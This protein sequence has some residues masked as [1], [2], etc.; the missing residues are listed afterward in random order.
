MESAE[1]APVEPESR[2]ALWLGRL[3]RVALVL[4]GAP[5]ILSLAY[6]ILPPPVTGL[7][8]WKAA[9]G[10]GIDYRWVPLSQISP[11]LPI[12]VLAAEDTRFCQH[13]A[14]DWDSMSDVVENVMDDGPH[15]R[16]KL[17][18]ASTITMQTAKNLF[19][20]PGRSFLRKLLEAPLAVWIDFTWSKRRVLEVYLNVVEWGPGIYGAEAA[21]RAHFKKSASQ[22]TAREAA[23]LAAVLPNPIK[24][25]AGK[26][27]GYVRVYAA[28]INAR[29][30]GTVPFL[31]CLALKGP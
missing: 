22:L 12:A 2:R 10:Y 25:I 27:S 29:V 30:P 24:R 1:T 23:L 31:D 11:K 4:V 18:G 21:A 17:R 3:R 9:H 6:T 5:L 26:P 8:L 13:G 7:M 19:L 28:R 16:R 20:W 14:I 15:H